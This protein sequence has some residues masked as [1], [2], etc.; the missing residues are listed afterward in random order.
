MKK[1]FILILFI[2]TNTLFALDNYI[3]FTPK[4]LINE[5]GA[6]AWVLPQRGDRAQEDDVMFFYNERIYIYFNQNR[7]W[8]MRVDESYT[9]TVLKLKLGDDISVVR[10]ILGEPLEER[11]NSFI[12]RRPD[13]GYPVILRLYFSGEKLNDIYMYRGDY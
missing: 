10:E 2:L 1:S 4:E 3:G 12:Y 11:E 13:Q 7:V 9:G 6:P 8:Q 5:L